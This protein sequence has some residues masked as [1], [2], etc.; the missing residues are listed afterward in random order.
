[1]IISHDAP[2]VSNHVFIRPNGVICLAVTR[3]LLV[4]GNLKVQFEMCLVGGFRA[5][6]RS[7][8]ET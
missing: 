7:L 4:E 5:P 2:R 1:M 8:V 6:E 3:L